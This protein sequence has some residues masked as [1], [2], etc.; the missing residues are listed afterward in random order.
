MAKPQIGDL[1]GLYVVPQCGVGSPPGAGAVPRGPP[2]RA[3]PDWGSGSAHSGRLA[4]EPLGETVSYDRD[5]LDKIIRKDAA[6]AVTT[7][8]YDT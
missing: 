5:P 2:G 6:G 7:Y 4:E 1:W 8:V 3:V